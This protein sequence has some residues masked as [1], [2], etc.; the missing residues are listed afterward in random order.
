MDYKVT[1]IKSYG[2]D[3]CIVEPFEPLSKLGGCTDPNK[4]GFGL[5]AYQCKIDL[6]FNSKEYSVVF[7]PLERTSDTEAYSGYD[8]RVDRK[9]DQDKSGT[10]RY[11]AGEAEE[12]LMDELKSLAEKKAKLYL[13]ALL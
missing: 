11:A 3:Y 2:S 9:S 13:E 4:K 8:L 12:K 5:G 7:V 6:I 10:L 1:N